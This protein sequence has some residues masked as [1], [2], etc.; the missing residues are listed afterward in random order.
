LEEHW[1]RRWEIPNG[2]LALGRSALAVAQQL[3]HI[4]LVNIFLIF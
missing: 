3:A 1:E 2:L 4:E